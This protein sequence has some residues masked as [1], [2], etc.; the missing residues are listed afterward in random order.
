MA[1]LLI[2]LVAA[3]AVLLH[4]AD[5][6]GSRA[7]EPDALLV[8][9]G[10]AVEL[11]GGGTAATDALLARVATEIGPA[12]AAV[13]EFWGLDW[14]HRIVIEATA[15]NAQ[16]RAAVAAP[17]AADTAAVAIA[18]RVDP[19]RRR[20]A[21]QRI[22]LAPG[23]AAMSAAALRIVLRHELFHYATRAVTALDAPRWLVEGVADYVARET[24]PAVPPGAEL[25][26]PSD[27]ELDTPGPHRNTAYDRAWW[28]SRFVA[29]RYGPQ[30]LRDLYVAA[31]GVDHVGLPAAV[32]ASLG[33]ELPRLLAQWQRWATG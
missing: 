5:E 16:F 14:P 29:D 28:F 24:D 30:R 26:L 6:P 19:A 3:A 15:T 10:R 32:R 22:V 33:V 23:A 1:L 25:T 7:A 17:V 31:C 2:E 8:G 13:E 4:R 27:A 11:L 9:D 12:T 21:G 18:T 20:A